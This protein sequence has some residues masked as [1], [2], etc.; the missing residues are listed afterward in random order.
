MSLWKRKLRIANVLPVDPKYDKVDRFI[1]KAKQ[2]L[3]I[4]TT[5]TAS[6]LSI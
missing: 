4:I 5:T 2:L 3:M 6:V 1:S